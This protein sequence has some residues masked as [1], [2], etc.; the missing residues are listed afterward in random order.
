LKLL[1]IIVPCYNSAEYMNKCI[2]SLLIGSESIEIIIV[3]DGSKDGTGAISDEYVLRYPNI[4]K[5]V[6]QKNGGHGEAINT[7]LLHATGDYFKVVDSDDWVDESAFISVLEVLKESLE[8]D[9]RIDML[10]SNFT[11]EK[12]GVK[13]KT[14]MKYTDTIPEGRVLTWDEIGNFKLG[15][16]ILMHSVIYR[17]QLLR[18]CDL[19][20]PKHTFYVDNLFVYLPLPHVEYIYYK[21]VDLYRYYIGRDDQSVNEK[22]MISRIDQ[23]IKVNKLMMNQI[24]ISKISNKNKRRYMLKYLEIITVVSSIL[25]IKSGT[26]NELQKKNELWRYIKETDSR[27]Y[28]QMRIGLLGLMVNLPSYIGRKISLTMYRVSQSMF[29]FN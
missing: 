5:V 16:Y 9:V 24:N 8:E 6:H 26:S 20:L 13:N 27:I 1:S 29:G 4:I 10:L 18:D 14:V 21:N 15:K 23:Q 28:Y 17:T 2:D 22:I 11:Y 19:K 25:L 12:T 7:G 3:N